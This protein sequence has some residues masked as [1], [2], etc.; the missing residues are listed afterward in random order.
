VAWIGLQTLSVSLLVG[1]CPPPKY[2][3]LLGDYVYLLDSTPYYHFLSS[4][5]HVTLPFSKCSP[6]VSICSSTCGSQPS[7]AHAFDVLSP[8]VIHRPS[9]SA[10]VWQVTLTQWLLARTISYSHGSQLMSKLLTSIYSTILSH[11]AFQC[12]LFLHIG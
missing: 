5:P 4:P 1:T 6:T 9:T 2:L 12:W 3:P 11:L 7:C 8:F 10:P